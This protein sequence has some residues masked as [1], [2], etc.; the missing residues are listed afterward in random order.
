M[1][2]SRDP[3]GSGRGFVVFRAREFDSRVEFLDGRRQKNSI[4]FHDPIC[5]RL[6]PRIPGSRT[7]PDDPYR[8]PLETHYREL[9]RHRDRLAVQLATLARVIADR[10]ATGRSKPGRTLSRSLARILEA[11]VADATE[12]VHAVRE[13]C[14]KDVDAFMALMTLA[15]PDASF[16]ALWRAR[17]L[18]ADG[19]SSP[20][21]GELALVAVDAERVVGA[22]LTNTPGWLFDP[23]GIATPHE[24]SL[25]AR[26]VTVDGLA[27]RPE[28]RR[29]GIGRALLRRAE[30]E[31]REAGRGLSALF[32]EPELDSYYAKS[33]Y[34]NHSAFAILL[35]CGRVLLR[36]CSGSANRIAIK[37]LDTSVKPV[38]VDGLP[39]PVIAGLLPDTELPADTRVVCRRKPAE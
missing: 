37:P 20:E 17:R 18:V 12:P 26:I 11:P 27:V 22:L 35:P 3:D 5:D 33:G 13:A 34:T 31:M 19:A 28:H 6:R 16:E 36:K 30:D 15:A 9:R 21:S 39:M 10:P 2:P 24:P 38:H 14:P 25:I 8:N 4:V 32:H 23:P 7:V 1:F 29:T